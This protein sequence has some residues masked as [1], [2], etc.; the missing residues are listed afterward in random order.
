MGCIETA[1]GEYMTKFENGLIV[2]WDVLKPKAAYV[3]ASPLK[4]NSNMGCIETVRIV[5]CPYIYTVINSNMG[6]IETNRHQR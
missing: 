4:I 5:C 6:C 2:T 3:P 1:A